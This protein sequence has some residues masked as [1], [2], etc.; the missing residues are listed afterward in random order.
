MSYYPYGNANRVTKIQ[1]PTE[2][3]FC[4]G[5]EAAIEKDQGLPRQQRVRHYFP[6]GKSRSRESNTLSYVLLYTSY[7]N[8]VLSPVSDSIVCSS[9]K[10]EVENVLATATA[11][12]RS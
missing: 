2:R 11:T 1:A 10:A 8:S 4:E 9:D 5:G 7:R 12:A 3:A 6:S